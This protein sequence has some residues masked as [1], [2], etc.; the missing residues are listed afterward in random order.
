MKR[1]LDIV[2]SLTGL[3]IF[4]PVLLT[5]MLLIW[6]QDFHNPLYIPFRAG[7]DKKPFRMVKLRSMVV[8]ADKNKVDS[9]SNN[10]SRITYVGKFIRAFK[11]DEIMQLWNVLIGDMS[12]VGPRPNIDR[13]TNLYT[14][15]E[16]EL[17]NV[18]PGITDFSSIVFADEGSILADKADPDLAYN[19][20]IRPWKSRL[21][22]F[23]VNNCSFM[24]DIKLILLTIQVILNRPRALEKV[25]KLLKNL[26]ADEKLCQI[27]KR[28]DSLIPT[29]PPGMEQV[30]TRRPQ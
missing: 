10:D 22:I 6:L 12:L 9:T 2:L 8:N 14:K 7:K 17:L 21:G 27:A 18:K 3:I 26:G 5:T 23:Y 15:E 13:E 30:I 20:L 24:V 4:S 19:Q 29:P 1:M 16:Q 25:S 28:Q 11:L